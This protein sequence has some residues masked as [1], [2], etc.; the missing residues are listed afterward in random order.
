MLCSDYKIPWSLVVSLP[1]NC[2]NLENLSLALHNTDE[3]RPNWVEML[4]GSENLKSLEIGCD[5]DTM[6]PSTILY[7]VQSYTKLEKLSI[8]AAKRSK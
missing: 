8:Q 7:L 3:T 4:K 5:S 6:T 2:R 1:A